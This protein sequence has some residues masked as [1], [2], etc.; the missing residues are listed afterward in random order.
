LGSWGE[1]PV[2]V[3]KKPQWGKWGKGAAGQEPLGR[4]R[5]GVGFSRDI[6]SNIEQPELKK[7]R[8]DCKSAGIW[9]CRVLGAL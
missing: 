3:A 9:Y 4:E 5:L 7:K 6:S 8:K 2:K 1:R